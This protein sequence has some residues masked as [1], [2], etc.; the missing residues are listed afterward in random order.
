MS[1]P[2]II[3][4]L[5][6]AQRLGELAYARHNM[7][8]LLALGAREVGAGHYPLLVS[9][10][11]AWLAALVIFVAPETTPHWPLIGLFALLQAARLWVIWAL[12]PYWT[13]RIITLPDAPLVRRGPYRFCRHPNYLV[14][15]LEIAA[16]PLAFGA[17]KIALVFSVLNAVL[18]AHRIRI[19]N[20][21]LAGRVGGVAKSPSSARAAPRRRA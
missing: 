21:A 11:A 18:L 13:T 16:L 6:T 15:I 5:V 8:R 2:L 3:V 14:V 10:H 17:W 20:R 12:G 4:A 1:W 7:A 9:L 19:E